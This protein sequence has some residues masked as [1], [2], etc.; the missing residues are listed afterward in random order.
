MHE[1]VKYVGLSVMTFILSITVIVYYFY[2]RIHVT[3]MITIILG[4]TVSL[5]TIVALSL[6]IISNILYIKRK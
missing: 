6:S 1:Y 4:T 3:Y 5:L 2:S